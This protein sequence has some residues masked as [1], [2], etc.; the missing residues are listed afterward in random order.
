MA[1]PRFNVRE[2]LLD[3][4]TPDRMGSLHISNEMPD[5]RFELYSD[6]RKYG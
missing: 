4:I 3:T 5:Y 2:E 6:A 1:L